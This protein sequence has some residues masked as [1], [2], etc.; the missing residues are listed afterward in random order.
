MGNQGRSWEISGALQLPARGPQRSRARAR[1]APRPPRQRQWRRMRQWLTWRKRRWR[2]LWRRPWRRRRGSGGHSPRGS[3]RGVGR[4]AAAPTRREAGS[5]V[6]H[7]ACR[8]RDSSA[9]ACGVVREG[10]GRR[11]SSCWKGPSDACHGAGSSGATASLAAADGPAPS[12]ATRGAA[13]SI[14]SRPS[15]AAAAGMAAAAAAASRCPSSCA[16]ASISASAP[17]ASPSHRAS[18]CET[19]C[20]MCAARPLNALPTTVEGEVHGGVG[21]GGGGFEPHCPHGS[22]LSCPT[23]AHCAADIRRG[24]GLGAR[25]L[26]PA[27]SSTASSCASEWYASSKPLR[28]SHR[29]RGRGAVSPGAQV[30]AAAC[31]RTSSPG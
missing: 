15:A 5:G 30:A 17:A 31:S 29:A 24:D 13:S 11:T 23:A 7:D 27:V 25:V 18:H 2:W 21:G 14:S 19:C 9:R 10:Q 26:R 4:Q 12:T 1:A 28:C 6:S 16:A 8:R 22:A 3:G 20:T